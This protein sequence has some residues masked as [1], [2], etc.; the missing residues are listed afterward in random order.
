MSNN[1]SNASLMHDANCIMEMALT[2]A[3][4]SVKMSTEY[5]A[6][7]S[8]AHAFSNAMRSKLLKKLADGYTGW[9]SDDLDST[10]LM[11]ALKRNV[12]E[13]DMIDVANLAMMIWLRQ[14][15]IV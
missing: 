12:E 5:D 10:Y 1:D 9:R 8:V 3:R 4:D 2:Q 14:N 11:E 15:G 6:L 13:G 7:L